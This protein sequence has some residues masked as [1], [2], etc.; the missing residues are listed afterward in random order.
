MKYPKAAK[1][2]KKSS[3]ALMK[4]V[5]QKNSPFFCTWPFP[6]DDVF[7]FFP[8]PVPL[9]S[10]IGSWSGTWHGMSRTKDHEGHDT[11]I[12]TPQAP[13]GS[14]AG[15]HQSLTSCVSCGRLSGYPC[16]WIRS[17]FSKLWSVFLWFNCGS[18][19]KEFPWWP[20]ALSSLG[21]QKNC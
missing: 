9:D 7:D 8:L 3:D 21:R 13:S 2:Q 4:I 14:A 20:T 12:T 16:L 15:P 11:K 5:I 10:K 18:K 17:C 19:V 1:Y 6:F